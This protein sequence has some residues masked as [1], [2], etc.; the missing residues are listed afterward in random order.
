METLPRGSVGSEKEDSGE[1]STSE[2]KEHLLDCGW[3]DRWPRLFC[4]CSMSAVTW[5]HTV[6]RH[7]G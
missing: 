4:V 6:S 1:D 2:V 3:A 7:A 5:R